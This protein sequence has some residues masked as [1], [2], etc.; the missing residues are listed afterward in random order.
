VAALGESSAAKRLH[1]AKKFRIGI[2][3]GL[4]I[5]EDFGF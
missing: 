2:E 1:A 3:K 4:T 5:A